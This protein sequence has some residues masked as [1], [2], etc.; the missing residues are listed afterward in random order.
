MVEVERTTG[1]AEM[2]AARTA[3]AL[4]VAVLALGLGP[5]AQGQQD[6]TAG[7]TFFVASVGS[8]KGADLGG[9]AG[10]DAHCQQLA[11]AAGAGGTWRA[12]L[13][14]QA[15]G[16]QPA[17]NARERI[18]S[19]PWRNAQG[20]VIASSVEELHGRNNL[21]K[22]TALTEKGLPVNGRGDSPN[23]HDILTGSQ[24]DGT[25][26]A[27]TEDTTCGN[28]TKGGAEGA[29]MVGHHDRIGLRDDAPSRSWNSS[30]PTRGGCGQTALQGTGGAGLLYCFAA[31]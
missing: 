2:H 9:L 14:A 3:V 6:A 26:F 22:A 29:A 16:G 15:A 5:G 19:G 17:V 25:A 13:S 28:W 27:G 7:M 30:H 24:P 31:D 21:T 10:A 1:A 23:M 20:V 12:Y 11:E 4:G 8:G 18:G